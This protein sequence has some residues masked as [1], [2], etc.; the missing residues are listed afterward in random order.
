MSTE[1]NTKIAKDYLDAIRKPDMDRAMNLLSDD[2]AY[3]IIGK[4]ELFPVAG[5][6]TKSELR[7]LM[8]DS[9]GM[10]K[11]GLHITVTD[12]TASGDRVALE[13]YS[14]ADLANGKKY[15]NTYHWLFV[16]KNGKITVLKEY[17][18]TLHAATAFAP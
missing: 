2:L 18:D 15:N 12:V 11:D 17:M 16:V 13:A 6:L 10:F 14:N 1:D 9:S 3:H 5:V 4:K 8:A 7:K